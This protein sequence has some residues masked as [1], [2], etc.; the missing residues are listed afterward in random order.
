[1]QKNLAE[2]ITDISRSGST[3]ILTLSMSND[4]ALFKIFFRKGSIYHLTH[5]TCKDNDCLVNIKDRQF[6]AAAFM[7]GAQV[8]IENR[9]LMAQQ[10]IIALIRSTGKTVEWKGGADG[11][12]VKP[13]QSAPPS[14]GMEGLS[15]ARLEEELLNCI[16][17]VAPMILAKALDAAGLKEGAI[18]SLTE[19]QR[20]LKGITDQL[21]QEQREPF[22]KKF[23]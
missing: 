4:T 14:K 1:M 23:S 17:P 20:L 10:D 11:G 7:P 19:L 3:G 6:A 22:L 18:G 21:P 13:I 12:T 8:E 9:A 5:S 16:G 15:T 2:I